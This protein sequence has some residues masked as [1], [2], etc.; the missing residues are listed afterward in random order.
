MPVQT[1]LQQRRGTAAS[2]TSTNPTLAAGE[3]GFESDTNK[4]KIGTGSTAW[5][6]LA[7]ASNVS[8]LTTKGDLYTYSTDNTRLAVGANGETLVADSSTA[9]GLRYQV[10]NGLAQGAINGGF[11][12]WQRGTSFGAPNYCADRWYAAGGS[13]T[14]SQ[15][16]TAAN[17]PTGFRYGLKMTMSGTDVPY[18]RQAIETA[19]AIYFAGKRV[20]LSY[21]VASSASSNCYVGLNYSTSTDVAVTGSWTD[22]SAVSGYS[23][24]QA[25]TSTMSR[26][27]CVFDVPSDAKSLRIYAG[28][29][30]NITSGN[31]MTITGVLLEV[32]SVPTIFRRAGGTI[33]GELAAASRYYQKSYNLSV[34][35]ATSTNVGINQ[36]FWALSIPNN[37][38]YANIILPVKMRTAPTVTIYSEGGTAAAASK[39]S[40][41]LDLGSNSAIASILGEQTF[42]V[43][44][45]N[46]STQTT[47]QGTSFHYVAS[48][49]L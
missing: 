43:R 5:A 49:E 21:Y 1:Q 20:V 6:S 35:P 31:T 3:I 46:A 30:V 32:G 33:Q 10:G 23:A 14:Y 27:Y 37:S 38:P 47:T 28:S 13:T 18:V 42:T 45:Q 9:V 17:L 36:Q 2:W 22:I 48:A 24:T 11:D 7:Y 41:G 26:V 12:I 4:F 44:N 8:P 40:D 29:A 39:I 16:S 25:T 15:E 34:T 19:N